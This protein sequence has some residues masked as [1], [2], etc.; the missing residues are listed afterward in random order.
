MKYIKYD[1]NVSREI[2][3]KKLVFPVVVSSIPSDLILMYLRVD[4]YLN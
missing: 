1:G 2:K 4:S 3:D